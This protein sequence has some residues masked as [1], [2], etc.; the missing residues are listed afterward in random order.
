MRVLAPATEDDMVLLF[1][2][3][4]ID[5]WRFS[6]AL[7]EALTELGHDRSLV[8]HADTSD[9]EENAVRR[10]A[11]AR[12][13]GY[14]RNKAV[15]NGLPDDISWSW[16]M[17]TPDELAAVRYIDWD[18]WLD[19]TGGTRRP[20]DAIERMRNEWDSEGNDVCAI[21][22]S[23]A[24]GS[25]PLEII[26]LGRPPGGDLVVLEGHVRL[27]GLLLRPGNLPA[28]VRVLLGTSPRIE[29]WGLYG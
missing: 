20:A 29:E 18:Y 4:E 21:A 16:A 15:F 2:R 19:V 10:E 7:L 5:S 17:L 12:A 23:V 13:R 11:L 3:A 28:E 26:V 25:L 24:R 27:S 6:A 1:L 8:D 14:L 9:P 22:D